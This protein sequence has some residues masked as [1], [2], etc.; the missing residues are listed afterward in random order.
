MKYAKIENIGNS[1]ATLVTSFGVFL[2]IY[3]D[4][5]TTAS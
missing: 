1:E 5:T 2:W 3:S 4:S